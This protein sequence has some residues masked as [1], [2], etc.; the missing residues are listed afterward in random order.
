VALAEDEIDEAIE[1]ARAVLDPAQQALPE[2]LTALLEAA[3][4]AGEDGRSGAARDQLVRALALA[5]EL[6]YL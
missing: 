4:Q 2:G 6:N 3:L 1:Y 5:Q